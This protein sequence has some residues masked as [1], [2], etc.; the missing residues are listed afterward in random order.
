M[1]G[2]FLNDRIYSSVLSTGEVITGYIVFETD[3]LIKI[4]T[5]SNK[6][7]TINKCLILR[8]ETV[9]DNIKGVDNENNC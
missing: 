4:K 2:I 5:L 6:H 1:K 7:I 9:D 3:I 8:S